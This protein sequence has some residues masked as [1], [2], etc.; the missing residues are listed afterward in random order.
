MSEHNTQS[1]DAGALEVHHHVPS[2]QVMTAVFVALLFLT[3]LTVYTAMEVNL[4]DTGNLVVALAIATLKGALVVGFFMHL[5]WDKKINAVVLLYCLLAMFTFFFFTVIDLGSRSKVDPVR[6]QVVDPTI[7]Q[8]AK[9]A[10][11]AKSADEGGS[12]GDDGH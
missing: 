7:V 3:I 6:A 1:G 4:G 5:H 11:E 8:D 10:A 9:A 12:S 2:W